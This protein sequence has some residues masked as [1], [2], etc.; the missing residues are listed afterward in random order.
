MLWWEI[1]ES[2]DCDV[3]DPVCTQR[4]P[5]VEDEEAAEYAALC[6]SADP[7]PFVLDSQVGGEGNVVASLPDGQ[8]IV[9]LS[10]Q[11]LS[12]EDAEIQAE[13]NVR[14]FCEGREMILRLLRDRERWYERER[15][16][17]EEIALLRNRLANVG[18]DVCLDLRIRRPR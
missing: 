5:R 18:Q 16:L 12:E 2:D 10:D 7:G 17:L 9:S 4:S 1:D 3:F 6:Q 11:S 13:A 15:D 8:W 14:L